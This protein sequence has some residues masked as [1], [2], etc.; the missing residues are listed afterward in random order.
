MTP[1]PC[2]KIFFTFYYLYL[3]VSLISLK[4]FDFGNNVNGEDKEFSSISQTNSISLTDVFHLTICSTHRQFQLIS[5]SANVYTLFED[6]SMTIPWF[7]MGF[8]SEAD[9]WVGIKKYSWY[10]YGTYPLNFFRNWIHICFEID[11][12]SEIIRGSVNGGTIVINRNITALMKK[13]PVLYIGF[14]SK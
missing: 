5:N 7:T 13:P 3:K 10:L 14:E 11:F 6:Q 1:N 9:L 2:I 12:E 8:W 4:V